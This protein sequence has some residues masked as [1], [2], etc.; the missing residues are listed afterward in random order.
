MRSLYERHGSALAA[1]ACCG[2]LDFASAEDVVQQVFLKLLQGSV[3]FPQM[4]VAYLYRAVR[5]AAFNYRR[6]VRR[7]VSLP[8]D[9]AWLVVTDGRRDTRCS[10]GP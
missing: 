6:N 9:D 3:S 7:E 8:D 2:G 5:N 10:R 1:Y 4:P